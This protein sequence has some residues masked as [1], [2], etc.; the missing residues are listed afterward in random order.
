MFENAIIKEHFYF[1]PKSKTSYLN[2]RATA[3][4]PK[5]TPTANKLEKYQII[6]D[7][8]LLYLT[9]IITEFRRTAS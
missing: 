4:V 6:L 7:T 9:N 1:F 2:Y 8:V 3:R 5:N